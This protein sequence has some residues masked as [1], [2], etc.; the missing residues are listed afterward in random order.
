MSERKT[1]YDAVYELLFK[2]STCQDIWKAALKD[3]DEVKIEKVTWDLSRGTDTA[4]ADPTFHF[5]GGFSWSGNN[6]ASAELCA[7]AFI[8]NEFVK[9]IL[10]L[11]YGPGREVKTRNC[12]RDV[13]KNGGTV[14]RKNDDDER[15]RQYQ[16][17]FHSFLTDKFRDEVRKKMTEETKRLKHEVKAMMKTVEFRQSQHEALVGF[18]KDTITTALLPW[19]SMDQQVL[20]DAWD[21]FICTAI[22]RT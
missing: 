11:H 19:H 4:K 10:E 12:K 18:C 3:L 15:E 21:Q 2:T 14:S 16:E 5:T 22:M 17:S 1:S 7:E 13:V 9:K 6:L 8:K 20:Q